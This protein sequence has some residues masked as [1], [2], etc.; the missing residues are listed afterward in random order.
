MIKN[1]RERTRKQQQVKD[2]EQL[3]IQNRELLKRVGVSPEK[4]EEHIAL[5]KASM[6]EI[7]A[8]IAEYDQLK[9][10]TTPPSET[11]TRI[12]DLLVKLRIYKGLTQ[13]ALAE[14]M[15]VD[16]TQVSRDERSHYK[17]VSLERLLKVIQALEV[18]IQCNVAERPVVATEAPVEN[19]AEAAGMC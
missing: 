4:I 19:P 11:I 16:E 12:G 18:E 6:E 3:I 13:K 9:N 14:R 10:H 8:E 1:E 15:G 5:N 17:G 7:K 2:Y